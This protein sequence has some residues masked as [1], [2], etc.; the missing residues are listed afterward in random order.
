[1]RATLKWMQ[2]CRHSCFWED[3]ALMRRKSSNKKK[4]FGRIINDMCTFLLFLM[5]SVAEWRFRYSCSV[6][7]YADTSSTLLWN[8]RCRWLHDVANFDSPSVSAVGLPSSK[9]GV[10]IIAVASR[11]WCLSPVGSEKVSLLSKYPKLHI[12]YIS[13]II[14]YTL[15]SW[16]KFA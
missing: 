11:V 13:I 3:T 7:C 5:R 15:D 10:S 2:S 8:I 12:L 14:H 9:E 1:M 6:C 4:S 16:L